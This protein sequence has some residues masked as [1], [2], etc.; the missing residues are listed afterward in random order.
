FEF[1]RNDA[2]D[3]LNYFATEPTPLHL[4]QFGGNLGGPIVKDKLL[5]FVNYEGVRQSVSSPSGPVA[6][7]TAAARAGAVPSMVPVVDTL[8]LP[9]P[10][11]GPVIF[12]GGVTNPYLGYYEGNL[13]NT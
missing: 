1:F 5:F 13:H 9:N 6:V 2:F 3:A 4:N 8:P 7:L 12:P 11:L 10:A